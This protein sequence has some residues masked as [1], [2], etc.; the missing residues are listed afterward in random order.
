[1]PKLSRTGTIMGTPLYMAPEQVRGERRE[2][3]VRT[4][5]WAVGVIL[6]EMLCGRCPFVAPTIDGIFGQILMI[7]PPRPAVLR[8][9]LHPGLEMVVLR[10]LAKRPEDRFENAEAMANALARLSGQPITPS[11]RMMSPLGQPSSAPGLSAGGA[12][13]SAYAVPCAPTV[14]PGMPMSSHSPGPPAPGGWPAPPQPVPFGPSNPPP[15]GLVHSPAGSV[16]QAV[17]V[18]RSAAQVPAPASR[19]KGVAIAIAV[20]GVLAAAGFAL[21]RF[22]PDESEGG[23]RATRNEPGSSGSAAG[24]EPVAVAA[25]GTASDAAS[26]P[27]VPDETDGDGKAVEPDAADVPATAVPP[28]VAPIPEPPEPSCVPVSVPPALRGR[29]GCSTFRIDRDEVEAGAYA[30]CVRAGVCEGPAAGE[31][32][33]SARTAPGPASSVSRA[34]AERYCGWVGGR[35]PTRDEWLFAARGT[36]ERRYSWGTRWNPECVKSGGVPSA[37]GDVPACDVTPEG[38]RALAGNVAELIDAGTDV[39]ALGGSVRGR[40]P[41]A[42]LLSAERFLGDRDERQPDVGF[43]CAYDGAGVGGGSVVGEGTGGSRPVVSRPDAGSSGGGTSGRDVGGG[44]REVSGVADT[45][46]ARVP[47]PPVAGVGTPPSSSEVR[48]ALATLRPRVEACFGGQSGTVSFRATVD[49]ASGRALQIDVQIQ[50]GPASA[51][52]CI[53]SAISGAAL[54]TSSTCT[55][56][57]VPQSW[58]F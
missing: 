28:P 26:A 6:F 53:R 12:P 44:G 8:P 36:R 2:Q 57:P 20:L 16:L 18:A 13:S 25:G 46:P 29:I 39:V 19:W 47:V 10:A 35:L 56:Y 45:G 33:D 40:N 4:D 15:T 3:D 34:E 27:V 24:T 22:L 31:A 43:R 23:P 32:G 41:D 17:P 58:T 1:M 48:R 30:R 51:A 42:F 11:G 55:S 9:G 21:L 54:P 38:I 50:A 52:G 37:A 14:L 5:L 7:E 49:C